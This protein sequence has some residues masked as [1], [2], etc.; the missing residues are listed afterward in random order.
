MLRSIVRDDEDVRQIVRANPVRYAFPILCSFLLTVGPFFFLYLLLQYRQWGLFIFSFLLVIGLFL[1][2][3]TWFLWYRNVFII[4]NQRLIDID[5]KSLFHRVV[6]EI[7][8]DKIQDVSFSIRGVL[9]TLFHFGT[10]LVQTAGKMN[11][12]E[13]EGIRNPEK[14]QS[15]IVRLQA[16]YAEYAAQHPEHKNIS[17]NEKL[18]DNGRDVLRGL[19]KLWGKKKFREIVNELTKE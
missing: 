14:M 7:L 4:T 18:F 17:E 5:Q 10:L 11:T 1:T 12:I 15:T 9:P 8:Y 16:E 3:R 2:F 13:F 6:S 19:V